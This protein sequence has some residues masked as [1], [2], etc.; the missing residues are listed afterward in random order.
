MTDLQGRT[1]TKNREVHAVAVLPE[2]A[3]PSKIHVGPSGAYYQYE[4]VV[5]ASI[6]E[7]KPRV[8]PAHTD[9]TEYDLQH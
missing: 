3:T 6:T 2:T 8:K 9:H 5:K 4:N 7:I 1:E